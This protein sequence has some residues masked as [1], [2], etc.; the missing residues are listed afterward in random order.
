MRVCRA[1]AHAAHVVVLDVPPILAQ[2]QRDAVGA[3]LLGDQRREQRI[4]IA[5]RGAPGAGSRRDRCSP[6]DGLPACTPLPQPA[7]RVAA[8]RPHRA[9]PLRRVR[10]SRPSRH[11]FECGPQQPPCVG[12]TAGI[13]ERL[14]GEREQRRPQNTKLP[15]A[16]PSTSSGPLSTP[17]AIAA[18]RLDAPA[19]SPSRSRD[20]VR[21]RAPRAAASRRSAARARHRRA[22]AASAASKRRIRRVQP[23]MR[24]AP[25]Q[26]PD[27]QLV[28]IAARSSAARRQRRRRCR[29]LLDAGQLPGLAA[30]AEADTSSSPNGCSAAAESRSAAARCAR[31]DATRPC[32]SSAARGCG[33]SPARDSDAAGRRARVGRVVALALTCRT[34]SSAAPPRCPTSLP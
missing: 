25:R 18:L 26:Q 23:R 21:S 12:E 29:T 28:R 30:Q 9:A 15:S 24:I 6:R 3:G 34:R 11:L 19:R 27:Q 10:S 4:G 8:V 1:L 5:S 20:S 33:W 22:G 14:R 17:I 31:E 7:A 2:V 16:T 13:F 32:D